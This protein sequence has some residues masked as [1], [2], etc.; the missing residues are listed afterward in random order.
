MFSTKE[1]LHQNVFKNNFAFFYLHQSVL[2]QCEDFSWTCFWH[3]M[4][5][6]SRA[7]LSNRLINDLECF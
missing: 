7:S 4:L 6:W 1:K 3:Y 5:R 2:G